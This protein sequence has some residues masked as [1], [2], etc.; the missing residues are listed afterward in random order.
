MLQEFENK[1]NGI[2][3][4]INFYQYPDIKIMETAAYVLILY[5]KHGFV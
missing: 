3:I 5:C 4:A 1:G 2:K